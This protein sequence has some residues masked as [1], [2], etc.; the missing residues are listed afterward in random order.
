MY[1]LYMVESCLMWQLHRFQLR[2]SAETPAKCIKLDLH[3][4]LSQCLKRKMDE[5]RVK[6]TQLKNWNINGQNLWCPYH[7]SER[8]S[9]PAP[10][11]PDRVIEW[12]DI[13]LDKACLRLPGWPGIQIA[14][15]Q[16]QTIQC[17]QVQHPPFLVFTRCF[18]GDS[19]R[20]SLWHS[21]LSV[22][23]AAVI[24]CLY[25]QYAAP[26]ISKHN[27]GIIL[28]RADCHSQA[29]QNKA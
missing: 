12:R 15:Y 18:V 28:R 11:H 16:K 21:C 10:D 7:R 24:R 5:Q 1:H 4:I 6:M 8:G 13:K 9:R 23:P 20:C 26:V 19:L 29:A 14:Q 17:L 3:E 27:R 22:S 2:A 25:K